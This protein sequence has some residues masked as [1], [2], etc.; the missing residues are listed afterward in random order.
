MNKKEEKIA[1]EHQRKR[2]KHKIKLAV[3]GLILLVIGVTLISAYF[4]LNNNEY[5]WYKEK[6][7][8]DYIVDLK[9]NEFYQENYLDEN[10]TVIASL[11]KDIVVNFNYNLNLEQNQEYTY[12]YKIEAKTSVKEN[13]KDNTIYE[14]TDELLSKELQQQNSKRLQI[15]EQVTINYDEYNDK[16]NKFINLYRL[17]NT[18]STLELNMYVYVNNKY[19][20]TQINQNSKVMVLNIPLTTKT[21]DITIGSNVVQNEGEILLRKNDYHHIEVLLIVGIVFAVM[22]AIIL[23]VLIKYVLDTRS[24]ETMY[25]QEL[26]QILFNFKAYIQET[27][28]EIKEDEYKVIQINTFNEILGLRDTMQSPILMYTD[29]EELRTKFVIINDGIL[30]VYIL[31]ASEIR[32]E[33]RA[34][35]AK[36]MAKQEGKKNTKTEIKTETKKNKNKNK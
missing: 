8:V 35:H 3:P 36:K 32:N 19:D 23:A 9:E 20:N 21:V 26:K 7:N 29:E 33:L 12:S 24:A 1:L 14:T 5:N 30:Y 10:S 31:G 16:I 15:S 11:I 34:I 2:R 18:T 6:A 28:N 17:D 25:A 13:S 27:N 22:G 4:A